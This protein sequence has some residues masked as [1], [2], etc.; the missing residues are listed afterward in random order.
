MRRLLLAT[1][2][3]LLVVPVASAK[4]FEAERLNG[5]LVYRSAPDGESMLSIAYVSPKSQIIG[6]KS[7]KGIACIDGADLHECVTLK[8]GKKTTTW[9]VLKPIKLMHA[10]A[11]VF[12]ITLRKANE[13]RDVF[14][15]GCGHVR[16]NGSGNYSADGM[17]NVAYTPA[18][19]PVL[20]SLQP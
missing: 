12:S 17:E 3:L 10:Q 11:G 13:V 15:S 4:S 1:A 7:L 14:I 20:I 18:D 5:D 6:P 2:L 8:R 9:T 19:A 16:V